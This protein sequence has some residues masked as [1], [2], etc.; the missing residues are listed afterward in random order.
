MWILKNSILRTYYTAWVYYVIK[1]CISYQY[2]GT[3]FTYCVESYVLMEIFPHCL[4]NKPGQSWLFTCFC[5][6][7]KIRQSM[8]PSFTSPSTMQWQIKTAYTYLVEH[9][10]QPKMFQHF[11]SR[12]EGICQWWWCVVHK[13]YSYLFDQEND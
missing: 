4:D 1:N 12:I 2:I 5:P 6:F 11:L 7:E 10:S 8:C 3:C 13:N 9:R